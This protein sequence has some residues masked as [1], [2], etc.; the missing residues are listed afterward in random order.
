MHVR[1]VCL[2]VTVALSAFGDA[3]TASAAGPSRDDALAAIAAYAPRALKEQGAPGMAVAVTDGTRVLQLL[4]LGY[5]NVD[6]KQPVTPQTRFPIG[7][8]TKS[9]TSLAL[10]QLVDAGTLDLDAPV[11]QY[12]PEFLINSAGKPILVHQLLSHTGGIPDDYSLAYGYESSIYALRDASVLFPPGTSFSYAND[13]YVTA[14]GVLA[15]LD[16]RAWS[17]SLRQRVFAPIGM[18]HSSPVF[19]QEAFSDAA[20]GYTLRYSDRP[21]AIDPPLVPTAPFDF[22]DPAGSVISTPEDMAAYLRFYLNGGVTAN[23]TRLISKAAFAKMT[24]PDDMNGKPAGSAGPMLAE[25]P[26]FYRQY[27]FGLSL[28]DDGG[29]RVIAHTGGISGYTSCMEANLTRGFGV[30]ALS[31]LVEAPLH[32]CAIVLYAMRVLRAQSLGEALP[33]PPPAP[34]PA[35]VPHAS[36]FAGTYRGANGTQIVIS[37]SG[38]GAQLQ[39]GAATYRIY[40]RGRDQFWSDDPR[41]ALFTLAFYRNASDAVTDFTAG[42]EQFVNAAYAGPKSFSYPPAYDALVGR[43]ET[44]FVGDISV[45]RV[46]EVKGHLTLDGTSPLA[47][48]G[49]GTFRLG[50]DVVRFDR[51]FQ[52]HAQRMWI[53]GIPMERIELP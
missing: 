28:I 12:L 6:A 52:G 37:P 32:P 43:Y 19:T 17:D 46:I 15:A 8:I 1:V 14:G 40:P 34:D 20:V 42:P 24:T 25:A 10:M 3:A 11:T 30:I 27:G 51:I 21:E 45:T 48:Q 13:G 49:N 47:D 5:A 35:A 39:D 29:D 36:D 23:G 16:K 9:M 22:V 18:T 44:P 53:D 41:F 2:A 7:S 33:L 50:G 31:N 4:T 38:S 26:T